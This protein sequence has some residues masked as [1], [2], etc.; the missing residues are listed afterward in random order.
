MPKIDDAAQNHTDI[1]NLMKELGKIGALGPYIPEEYGG[2]GLDQISYGIIMQ[3]LGKRRF[4]STFCGFCTE[5]S[6][7]VPDQRIRFRRTET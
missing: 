4:C 7:D 1:P 2:S 6:G 3:E 5:F